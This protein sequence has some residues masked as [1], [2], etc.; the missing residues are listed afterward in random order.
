MRRAGHAGPS[1]R[2][3]AH[4]SAPPAFSPNDISAPL[5]RLRASRTHAVLVMPDHP[6]WQPGQAETAAE[7][8]ADRRSAKRCGRADGSIA[9]SAPLGA[10]APLPQGGPVGRGFCGRLAPRGGTHQPEQAA[11]RARKVLRL[12]AQR[13]DQGLTQGTDQGWAARPRRTEAGTG[14]AAE[15]ASEAARAEGASLHRPRRV[16]GGR[17]AGQA[18]K[19][20]WLARLDLR[21]GGRPDIRA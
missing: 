4:W 15:L 7:G 12:P 21:C 6:E 10:A 9:R 11:R 18:V 20:E 13:S 17:A 1:G 14:R 5:R 19:R 2:P 16:A 8:G 3:V